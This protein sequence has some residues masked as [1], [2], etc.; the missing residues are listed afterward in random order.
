MQGTDHTLELLSST[1][2]R[3]NGV[4]PD[5]GALP[6]DPQV[7]ARCLSHSLMQ[8]QEQDLR[9][10]WL[11]I[12][13]QKSQLVPAAVDAGFSFHHSGKDYLMLTLSLNAAACIPPH[14]THYIGAGGVVLSRARELLVVVEKYYRTA[15]QPPRYK[16][17]GGA[18]HQG[19]HLADGVRREVFEETGVETVF[20][21]LICFRHWHEY[22]YGKSD[23]Y[24]VCRLDPLSEEIRIQEEEIDECRWMPV[25]EYLALVHVSPFNR[26]VVQAA[27]DSPGLALAEVEGY[28]DRGRYEVFMPSRSR[29]P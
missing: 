11:E 5:P 15:G 16:L 1:T 4:L 14:A 19:E 21:S 25:E 17:P 9:V 2:N 29:T 18:L 12:P 28:E 22:R 27:L 23:I 7:F 8:W 6:A 13:I 24:F 10:V 20:E 26:K 3:F